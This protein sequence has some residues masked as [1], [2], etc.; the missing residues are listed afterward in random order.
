MRIIQWI[1]RNLFKR[2]AKPLAVGMPFPEGWYEGRITP[3]NPE[4]LKPTIFCPAWINRIQAEMG[5]SIN[6]EDDP[7][8]KSRSRGQT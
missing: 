8:I 2:K 3:E 1:K 5:G 4:P 6:A 7:S